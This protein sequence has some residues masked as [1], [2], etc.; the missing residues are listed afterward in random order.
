MTETEPEAPKA[1]LIARWLQKYGQAFGMAVDDRKVDVYI[2]RL[3]GY[4]VK[5]L[6]R[7]LAMA[8]DNEQRF[9][10]IAA[11]RQWIEPLEDPKNPRKEYRDL[12]K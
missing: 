11:I 12:T 3:S 1:A 5:K 9:P 8:L 6:E 4:S 2:E 10:T 7:A